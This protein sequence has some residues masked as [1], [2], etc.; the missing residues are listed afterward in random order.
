MA[1]RSRITDVRPIGPGSG[2][3]GSSR[4]RS[5]TRA[6]LTSSRATH[7]IVISAAGPLTDFSLGALFSVLCA[8]FPKGS[9]VGEVFFQLAF[10]GYVGAFFNLNPFLD[11]DGYQILCEWLREPH[12]KQRA[13][14]QL[15]ERLSGQRTADE[16]SPVLARYAIA[17]LVWS[18]LG[19][20]FIIVLSD[21]YYDIFVKMASRRAL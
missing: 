8:V 9:N 2:C 7:R 3:C 6:R 21:R 1:S 18:A 11:R 19:A 13:R 4:T 20:G 12:L 14:Q 10:A 15:R 17:G 16:S 5:W